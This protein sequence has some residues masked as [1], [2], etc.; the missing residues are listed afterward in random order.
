[1]KTYEL[2]FFEDAFKEWK[3]LGRDVRKQ[4][5][6]KLEERLVQPRVASARLSGMRDC[7]KI[8][9]KSAGYRLVYQVEDDKLIVLVV[10][11]G[12]RERNAV[13]KTAAGRV[14]D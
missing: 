10:A 13:Y 11:I 7:Y 3:K 1:M 4:F 9:L 2:E 12:R 8:K 6:R 5:A 14:A